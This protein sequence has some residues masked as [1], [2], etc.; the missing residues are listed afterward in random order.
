MVKERV[1]FIGDVEEMEKDGGVEKDGE[2]QL[3]EERTGV[4]HLVH[5]WYPQGHQVSMCRL[6]FI[7]LTDYHP[8]KDGALC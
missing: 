6:V 2:G 3:K 5:C 8:G 1:D 7:L 4:T